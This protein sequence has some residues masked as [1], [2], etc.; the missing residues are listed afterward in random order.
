MPGNDIKLENL[1]E[2]RSAVNQLRQHAGL[3]AYN[4]TIDPNPER[5][6]T[7]VKAQHIRQLRAALEEARAALG[8]SNGGYA[9][10]TLIENSSLIYAIYF[11]ELRNQIRSAW[12]NGEAIHAGQRFRK[13]VYVFL[14]S[15]NGD[16]QVIQSETFVLK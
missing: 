4:F 3:G 9:H 7:S 5:N 1:T 13:L 14:G 12:N 8:L 11:Q 6:V 15:E 10:P 16:P 2:L